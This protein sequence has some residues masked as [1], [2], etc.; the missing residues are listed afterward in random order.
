MGLTWE[1]RSHLSH[2]QKTKTW[3]RSHIVTN[4]IKTIK[5]FHIKKN[6]KKKS[7]TRQVKTILTQNKTLGFM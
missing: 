5:M 2:G 1:L 4:L 3:N 6:L 7:V